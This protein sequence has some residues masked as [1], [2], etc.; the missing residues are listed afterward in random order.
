MSETITIEGDLVLDKDYST[1]KNL[2]VGGNITCKDGIWDIKAGNIDACDINA[3]DIKAGNIDAWDIDAGNIN[4]RKIDACD[5]DA[6][7]IDAWNINARKIDA[8][9]I[10]AEDINSDDIKAGNIEA[11]N[12]DAGDISYYAFCIAYERLYCKSI[13]GRR[14]NAFHRCLDSEIEIRKED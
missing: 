3:G 7:N 4:A 12:I 10:E 2:I 5:I 6:G 14:D 9:N 8:G 1:D 11:W 13:Q